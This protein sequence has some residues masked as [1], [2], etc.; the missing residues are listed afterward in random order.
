MPA[1]AS[2]ADRG[3]HA[4]TAGAPAP[5]DWSSYCLPLAR[6]PESALERVGETRV[7]GMGGAT[8]ASS[9]DAARV[10][11]AAAER[12]KGRLEWLEWGRSGRSHDSPVAEEQERER[13]SPAA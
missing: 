12:L 9:A 13:H 2:T 4:R 6:A 8:R 11:E 5:P 10:A 3:A 1:S 7:R